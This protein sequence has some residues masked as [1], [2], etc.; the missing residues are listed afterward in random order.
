VGRGASEPSLTPDQERGRI[1]SLASQ[2]SPAGILAHEL[3]HLRKNWFWLLILGIAL[4]IVGIAAI[5]SAFIATLTTMIVIGSLLLVGGVVQIV[6]A[7]WAARWRTLSAE[8]GGWPGDLVRLRVRVT[9]VTTFS[10][11]CG[12][13]SDE[14]RSRRCHTEP[15]FAWECQGVV[16]ITTQSGRTPSEYKCAAARTLR[17]PRKGE[18]FLQLSP[19]ANQPGPQFSGAPA[20]CR[21]QGKHAAP[22]LWA[23]R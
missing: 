2:S 14:I 9:T 10:I 3:E 23:A 15:Q 13:P 22:D 4:I 12:S 6:N 5:G 11:A 18:T 17:L 21:G 19:F 20:T 8:A 16:S 7:I 1:M